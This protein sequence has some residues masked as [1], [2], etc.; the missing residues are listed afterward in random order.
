MSQRNRYTR[1]FGW[2]IV[3]LAKLSV[4]VGFHLWSV[5]IGRRGLAP[6]VVGGDDG[7]EY[8]YFAE[9][10]ARTGYLTEYASNV[11]PV[12][13]GHLMH[14]MGWSGTLPFKAV[15]LVASFGTAVLG[16]KLLRLLA[17][18]LYRCRPTPGAEVATA[19]AMLLF[20]STLWVASYS[21]Y[22]D[23]VLYFLALL[24]AYAAYRILVRKEKQYALP[25]AAAMVLLFYFRW[26]AT[27]SLGAGIVVWML[28]NG[29]RPQDRWRRRALAVV[30]VALAVGGVI[31]S[32]QTYLFSKALESRDL[33]DYNQGGSNLGL[34]Y[35]RS[36]LL[37][38]PLIYVYTFITNLIGPLPNQIEGATTLIG[39]VLEVPLLCYVLYRLYR[40]PATRRP[41][42]LLL[43][44]IAAVWFLLLPIYNDNVGTG[45]RLRVFGYQFLFVLFILDMTVR[46]MLRLKAAARHRAVSRRSALVSGSFSRI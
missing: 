37:L 23:A 30:V 4:V 31:A 2:L 36:S 1:T 20:P 27:V 33:F 32:G 14:A 9:K 11:W 40:S 24:V 10:I 17:A 45:L 41:E 7:E 26:Y 35:T 8:L 5:S 21:I 18:D 38:W 15:L 13:M 34:S 46:H 22:R 6:I 12:W 29:G 39:F 44:S 16:V 43:V 28:L 3:I 19:A 42:A 25:L